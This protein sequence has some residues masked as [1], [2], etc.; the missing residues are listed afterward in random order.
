MQDRLPASA[1]SRDQRHDGAH[2]NPQH[3]ALLAAGISAARQ[4][5]LADP[6]GLPSD[7]EI[8]LTLALTQLSAVKRIASEHR[9]VQDVKL[10][11]TRNRLDWRLTSPHHFHDEPFCGRPD[12][13]L[14]IP[15]AGQSGLLKI[16]DLLDAELS[17]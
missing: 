9:W 16:K 4:Q 14:S 17:D 7:H 12:W 15:L 13:F 11:A 10:S 5:P 2:R 8:S 3:I 6:D 1:I